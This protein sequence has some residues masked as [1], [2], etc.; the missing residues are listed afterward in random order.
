M[1]LFFDQL[2]L[3]LIGYLI[4]T[5]FI[6]IFLVDHKLEKILKILF[7]YNLPCNR[8]YIF[9]RFIIYT[10]PKYFVLIVLM[11][12]TVPVWVINILFVIF[13]FY[14]MVKMGNLLKQIN[15]K[16]YDKSDVK[17]NDIVNYI[18]DYKLL[19]K[20][21]KI[22]RARSIVDCLYF[23]FLFICHFYIINLF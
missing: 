18:F 5:S 10:I 17:L 1:F 13:N 12:T 21:S 4:I 11:F 23:I 19:N 7:T 8:P 16:F 22:I 20:M 9:I 6:G 15:F 2:L 3:F 14:L